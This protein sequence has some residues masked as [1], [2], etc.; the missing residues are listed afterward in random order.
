MA[1]NATPTGH[2]NTLDFFLKSR[3]PYDGRVLS[4]GSELCQR[5]GS[6]GRR[7]T[8]CSIA[9]RTRQHPCMY[10]RPSKPAHL[11]I[12]NYNTLAIGQADDLVVGV[13]V[14]LC[15]GVLPPWVAILA[16]RM[17]EDATSICEV[18]TPSGRSIIP[19]AAIHLPAYGL[20]VPVCG[21]TRRGQR[22][23]VSTQLIVSF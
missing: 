8:Q 7:T 12:L 21:A 13:P 18:E 1:L 19:D 4:S 17:W 20:V 10:R 5:A 14:L 22:R 23:W 11:T 2:A 3:I 9:P 6:R 16:I 15:L